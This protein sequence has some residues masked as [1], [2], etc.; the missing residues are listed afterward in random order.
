MKKAKEYASEIIKE[1]VEKDESAAYVK[2]A[3]S[4]KD[5]FSESEEIQKMRNVRNYAPML[6]I[7]KEQHL[8]W[9][10]ICRHVNREINILNDRAFLMVIEEKMTM[11]YPN[12]MQ[13][14]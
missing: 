8:K 10:S 14:I 12:L 11:I 7:L 9:Q 13:I 4:V 3:Q 1:Y 6:S 5:L 2:A